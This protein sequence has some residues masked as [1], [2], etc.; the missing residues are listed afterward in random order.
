[1]PVFSFKKMSASLTVT[2]TPLSYSPPRGPKISFHLT[3]N[4]FDPNQ[5]ATFS[6]SNL[7]PGWTFNW[8]TY[9]TEGP[10][11]G[12]AHVTRYV[13]GGGIEEHQGYVLESL[14]PFGGPNGRILRFDP[15]LNNR[16]VMRAVTS[17]SAIVPDTYQRTLGD[18]TIEFYENNAGG[19]TNLY[20]NKVID[21]QGNTVTI[22]YAPA[23]AQ[24]LS[25][26]DAIGQQTTFS[27]E[28]PSDGLKITRVT[29]PFGRSA[30]FTYDAQG[31]L[32]SSTDTQG[33]TSTFAYLGNTAFISSMTTPYGV[34]SFAS[35][36]GDGFRTLE[37]TDPLGQKQ[38]IEYQASLSSVPVTET[39]V[40]TGLAVNNSNLNQF[41]SFFWDA[42]AYADAVN[43][44]T[45]PGTPGSY[46]FAETSHWTIGEG[47][48]LTSIPSSQKKALESRVWTNY[49]G[50]S[51]PDRIGPDGTTL[52]NAI[53]RILDDGSTQLNQYSYNDT[54]RAT[55]IVD[56]IG[57][58]TNYSYSADGIDL[59]QVTQRNGANNDLLFSAAYDGQHL[60]LTVTDAAGQ[61]TTT[62][63]NSFGQPLTVTNP[64]GE[65]TT[66]AY[67]PN[68][69]LLSV[70][71]AIQGSATTLTY[72][73]AGR[74]RT[75]T[76]SEGY[77][78]TNAY[79]NLDRL[80]KQTFPDATFRQIAYDRLSL[81]SVT[82]RLG[83]T[84]TYTNDA[85]GHV[86]SI[87]DALGRITNFTWCKCGSLDSIQDA[88]GNVTSFTRDSEG[89]IT[90]K[91][92]A[93]N[94]KTS[95]VYENSTSRLKSRTDALGQ[96]TTYQYNSDDN[97]ASIAYTN[98][99]NA[100]PNMSFSYDSIYNRRVSITDGTGLTTFAY[101]PVNGQ[102][103]AGRL[104]SVT[105]PL[106][107][108]TIA[109]S[110]DQL[111]RVVGRSINGSVNPTAVTFDPLGRIVSETNNLGTFSTS[112]LNQT[113]RPLSLTYP[114]GQSTLY[115]YFDNLGDQRLKEIQNLGSGGTIL[116]QFDYSYDAE[117]QILSWG[118]QTNAANS[119]ALGYDLAGQ[120]TSANLS[121]ATPQTFAYV[122]D[123]AGNRTDETINAAS[124]PVTVNNLNELVA[125]TGANP[126]SFVYD[127]NG[128]LTSEIGIGSGTGTGCK[129]KHDD[130]DRH[131]DRD[132]DG[133][134][135]RDER[136]HEAKDRDKD[137]QRES[138][139]HDR[140]DD[141]SD[142]DCDDGKGHKH[143]KQ[144]VN[145]ANFAFQWDAEN[146]LV[147]I[148]NAIT[149]Q[150]TLFT[151]DGLGRRVKIVEMTG[152]T[153]N[154]TRQF[155]WDG[156]TIAEERDASGNV[157]KRFFAQGQIN[158]SM[159]FFYTRDHLG[160][161]REVAD[162]TG[163]LHTRYDYDPYG[164]RSVVSGTDV[165]DFGF[166]GHLFHALSGLHLA[167]YRAYSSDDGKWLSRDP[168]GLSVTANSYTF[169]ENDPIALIDPTG[170]LTQAQIQEGQQIAISGA[171][172]Q[173]Q[174]LYY[175]NNNDLASFRANAKNGLVVG[176]IGHQLG[177]SA[178][179]D[180]YE[181]S[182]RGYSQG[183]TVISIETLALLKATVDDDP[184]LFYKAVAL[185]ELQRQ[186]DFLQ[187]LADQ[188]PTC[189]TP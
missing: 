174:Q 62:T 60:P 159:P 150:Q 57:R 124:S 136:R 162:N 104:V 58:Q 34:T 116:S 186:L 154:A 73:A 65:A 126:F 63:Y 172:F 75:V 24:I 129:D 17:P 170:L 67:D 178:A 137:N 59:L 157:A 97:L 11:T 182:L 7:G 103:G 156:L 130:K 26:T 148:A 112:Y 80:T 19:G 169:V 5:P 9:I 115:Q 142:H 28:L 74:V 119:F 29:D 96:V 46:A 189:E 185:A 89:R 180:Q 54:G 48:L 77:T 134:R 94:S 125:R 121:G 135:D 105:G 53:A 173:A 6:S 147:S 92:Y 151:Y 90:A 83:R 184:S 69:F 8:L 110:Y 82:D 51:D 131:H 41:N 45:A 88:N 138:R 4:Q 175:L 164:L 43:A 99:K 139:K 143:Q 31:R 106:A 179:V 141:D 85:D 56:P 188:K 27:Y 111:G 118:Q 122:Y 72:D 71:G 95:F 84:T 40:P 132:H 160:S 2:D 61:T 36:E 158:G 20:L 187:Y 87:K 93:D 3:Y 140:D 39:S 50:Q 163:A 70:I 38:R 55:Q 49:Q 113:S 30:V 183:L 1:M 35:Q 145:S 117:G 155:V 42:K 18:G 14:N 76:D 177:I 22:N 33:F 44:G 165:A 168:L 10:V 37:A 171:I 16:S 120:L 128:N 166:T 68:G 86:T 107:N 64:K 133:D 123:L 52:P 13:P 181:T 109:Y 149:N 102:I 23:S 146:R 81:G 21:P 91:T 47:G 152:T 79:D 127:A 176:T 12:Q 144:V 161:I 153:V 98:A 66:L 15:Q 25:I 108:S 100:T 114:N 32:A 101:N 167:P 78:V